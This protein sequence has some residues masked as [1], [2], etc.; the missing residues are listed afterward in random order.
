[1]KKFTILAL[2][3]VLCAALFTGCRNRSDVN[4]TTA[5]MPTVTTTPTGETTRP[6]TMPTTEA[7]TVT[8]QPATEQIPSES[9]HGNTE[10]TAGTENQNGTPEGRMRGRIPGQK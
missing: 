5:P 10:G 9:V 7:P 1:M 6:T 2:V 8:T 3:L 4:N